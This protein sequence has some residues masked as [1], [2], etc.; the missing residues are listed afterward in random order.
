MNLEMLETGQCL[1][2]HP[3]FHETLKKKKR[4]VSLLFL[5]CEDIMGECNRKKQILQLYEQ[6]ISGKEQDNSEKV[7]KSKL[8][9]YRYFLLTD[10]LLIT[11]FDNKE[12]GE[13]VFEAISNF[14]GRQ[15]YGK[16]K[17]VFD[18][19]YRTNI[20]HRIA[21]CS[22]LYAVYE[23]VIGDRA[24]KQK[25]GKRTVVNDK[26]I[27][28]MLEISQYLKVHPILRKKRSIRIRYVSLL[29]SFCKGAVKENVW[30]R[31]VLQL[32][33]QAILGA[34]NDDSVLQVR[35][36]SFIQRCLFSG[37]K[38]FLLTDCLFITAFN[39]KKKGEKVFENIRRFYRNRKMKKMKA[40]FDA[41]YDAGT[42]QILS[43]FSDLDAIYAIIRGNRNFI[44]KKEKRIMITANMSAGKSTLLNA[45]VGKKINKTLND[46]CT[47]KIHY[48]HNKFIEDGYIYE[49]DDELELNASNE[50]LM[51]DNE[52]NDTT[53]I[54][55]GTKFRSW[56][57][58]DKRVCFIDT[59]GVNSSMDKGHREI[60][61]DSITNIEC[62]LLIYLF[63][64]EN[65]GTDDDIR[66]LSYVHDH[67]MGK[68]IFLIN[69]VDNYKTGTDSV[70]DTLE[71]EYKDLQKLGFK[72]PE[73]YPVSAYAAY[74]AKM[75]LHK[76]KLSEDEAEELSALK[77]RLKRPE[78]SYE[79]YYKK[80]IPRKEN[81][82]G[83]SQ[84][85]INSGI[86]A[87]EQLLYEL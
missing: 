13:Q 63:N 72:N 53:D 27:L 84:L 62:D 21:E 31:Q 48:I 61:D 25:K 3:I 85:L 57:E 18:T 4:Y 79:Q 55:V 11:A 69:R 33:T 73:I 35:D 81:K 46:S 37:Y 8:F 36:L 14:Y 32:Y 56:Q 75:A 30:S 47:A 15:Y 7:D 76:E 64:G 83:I 54:H 6:A 2:H 44:Q 17:E 45:L 34:E 71:K 38:Y 29:F 39:D 10:C 50:I 26:V 51:N 77:R 66:H 70:K 65:I 87:L 22:D 12:T 1:K 58:I 24:F 28:E 16:L 41:F 23:V 42:K 59:P 74:L 43:K 78:F 82:D 80:T 60:T 9:D 67:Y 20:R 19:F 52:E 86:I 40:V 49:Y 5:F 68:I